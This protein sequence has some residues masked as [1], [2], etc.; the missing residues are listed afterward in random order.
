MISSK[1]ALESAQVIADFCKE[2]RGCQNCIF[3][4]HGTDS[5]KCHIDAFDLQGVLSNIE[6]KKKNRGYL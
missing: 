4:E 5:W 3:R 2:Q 6:A 1:K